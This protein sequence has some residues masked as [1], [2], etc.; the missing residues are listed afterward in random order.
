[1][2]GVDRKVKFGTKKCEKALA[3]T[4]DKYDSL[5]RI[6]SLEFKYAGIIETKKH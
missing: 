3:Q 6:D 2:A 1:M 5:A 4:K